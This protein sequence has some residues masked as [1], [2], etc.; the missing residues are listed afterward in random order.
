MKYSASIRSM[1]LYSASLLVILEIA[2][3]GYVPVFTAAVILTGT[4]FYRSVPEERR[5]APR[6]S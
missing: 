1:G 5:P 6:V 2:Y 3:A 4:E